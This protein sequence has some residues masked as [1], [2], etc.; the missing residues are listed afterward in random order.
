L[1]LDPIARLLSPGPPD[2]TFSARAVPPDFVVCNRHC[3]YAAAD[4]GILKEGGVRA[5][6]SVS[7]ASSFI[8]NANSELYAFYTGKYSLMKKIPSQ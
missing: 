6:D 8:A 4:P 5:E 1:S 2:P 7:F 3:C